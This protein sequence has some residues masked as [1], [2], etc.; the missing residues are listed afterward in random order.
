MV[1]QVGRPPERDSEGNVVSKSL[2]NVTI[3]TKLRDF[4]AKNKINRSQLFTRVVTMLYC[5]A[6]CPKCYED[7][8]TDGIMAIRCD[9]C[10]IVIKY[11]KCSQCKTPYNKNNLVKAIKGS[12]EFGCQTCQ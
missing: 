7:R 12:S 1:K 8:V 5:H 3:P 9:S 6:I 10:D 4:L 2:V 11:N